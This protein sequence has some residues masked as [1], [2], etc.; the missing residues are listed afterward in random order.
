MN[1]AEFNCKLFLAFIFFE[2]SQ[3]IAA[4]FVAS[5]SAHLYGAISTQYQAQDGLGGYSYGYSDPLSTKNEV[6]S[7]DGTLHGGYSYV[8]ANGH[9]QSVKYVA[10]SHNGFRVVA[11][12]N[13][14]QAPVHVV[15]A[16]VAHIA[17]VAYHVAAPV[18]HWGHHAY[19]PL[20]LA[21]PS[22]TPEVLHAEAKHFQAHAEANARLHSIHKRSAHWAPQVYSIA[23]APIHG[24]PQ[25][26]PAVAALKA[27]R[28]AE[29]NEKSGHAYY[30]PAAPAYNHY[31]HEPAH[32]Y[33]APAKHFVAA[34]LPVHG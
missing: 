23:P 24:V 12:T 4:L 15:A 33:A 22:K 25:D 9:V 29:L 34:P 28:I 16:P 8:D 26:E 31:A 11:A 18:E 21:G 32:Y 6:K 30:A 10:D 7:H 14:P 19:A 2:L 27:Q 5:C 20:A 13:L 17:P 1:Y 3:I